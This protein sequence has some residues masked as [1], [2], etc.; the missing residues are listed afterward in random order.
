VHWDNEKN[1]GN[2]PIIN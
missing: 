2:W 1:E